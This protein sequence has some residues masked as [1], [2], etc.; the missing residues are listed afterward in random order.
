[1]QEIGD[2]TYLDMVTLGKYPFEFTLACPVVLRSALSA[3]LQQVD[4]RPR[5]A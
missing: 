1:M 5:K 3:Q 2:L 4:L